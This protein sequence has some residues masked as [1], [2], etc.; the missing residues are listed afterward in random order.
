MRPS[1]RIDLSTLTSTSISYFQVNSTKVLVN[2]IDRPNP[3]QPPQLTCRG[4]FMLTI[5]DIAINLKQNPPSSLE[6]P[7]DDEM[8]NIICEEGGF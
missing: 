5:I 3:T 6:Y 8:R 1:R 7:E 2:F 4:G